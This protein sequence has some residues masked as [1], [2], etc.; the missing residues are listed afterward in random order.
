MKPSTTA[1]KAFLTLVFLYFCSFPILRLT[2]VQEFGVCTNDRVFG[3]THDTSVALRKGHYTGY[4]T[5]WKI[6]GYLSLIYYPLLMVDEQ[7]T[8]VDYPSLPHMFTSI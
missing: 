6:A 5:Q 2:L 4:R 8:G 3:M 1:S 7:I